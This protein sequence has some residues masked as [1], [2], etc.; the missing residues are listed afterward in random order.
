MGKERMG[1]QRMGEG[2]PVR[3]ALVK[4]LAARR[5]ITDPPELKA[6]PPCLAPRQRGVKKQEVA[7]LKEPLFDPGLMVPKHLLAPVRMRA[8]PNG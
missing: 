4:R 6:K 7:L 1:K 2:R 3:F 8:R 5:Q